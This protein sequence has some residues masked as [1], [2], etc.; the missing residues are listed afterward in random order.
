MARTKQN[1]A[2]ITV[3]GIVAGKSN[4]QVLAAIRK[5]HG[6]DAS[7]EANVAWYRSR[8]AKGHIDVTKYEAKK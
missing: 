3:R 8:I 7:S 6:K 5:A 1:I 4:K 2:T